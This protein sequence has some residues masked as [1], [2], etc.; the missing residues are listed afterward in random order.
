[1]PAKVAVMTVLNKSVKSTDYIGIDIGFVAR[2]CEP[3]EKWNFTWTHG[4]GPRLY[5]DSP[6][7][8]VN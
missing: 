8:R 5:K 4:E 1:M 2:G 7:G 3:R 6:C